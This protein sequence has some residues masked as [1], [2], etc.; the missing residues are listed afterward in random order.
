MN[1]SLQNKEGQYKRDFLAN[2][3]IPCYDSN[4][5]NTSFQSWT[6]SGEEVGARGGG[7]EEGGEEEGSNPSLFYLQI[8]ERAARKTKGRP[9]RGSPS[10]CILLPGRVTA[11]ALV[12]RII[13]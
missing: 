5:R 13:S 12:R 2:S 9:V 11:M 6:R 3:M 8:I 4:P 7:E 10:S 1:H